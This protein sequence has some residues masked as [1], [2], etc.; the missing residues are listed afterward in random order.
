MTNLIGRGF[1]KV[2]TPAATSLTGQH[3]GL[4]QQ[5]NY[6]ARD[7]YANGKSSAKVRFGAKALDRLG[8]VELDSGIEL[9]GDLG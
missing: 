5:A 6:L 3:P 9:A 2:K 1:A 8:L 4:F 7:G